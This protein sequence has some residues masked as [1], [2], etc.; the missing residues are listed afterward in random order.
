[1][2]EYVFTGT[3][4]QTKSQGIYGFLQKDGKV[5]QPELLA[6]RVSPTYLAVNKA[7]TRLYAVDEP[8]EGPGTLGS[9]IIERNET[10]CVTG[11][12]LQ[13][14]VTAP[15]LGL[16][17]V[18]LSP[19]EKYLLCVSY[20]DAKLMVYALEEDGSIGT[21]TACLKRE[22][23]GPNPA[24]QEGAHAHSIT[25]VPNGSFF[26]LL[27]LGTDQLAAYRLEEGVTLHYLPH[28]VLKVH[29]P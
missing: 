6:E 9:Y 19:D 29:S 14:N 25:F 22:G 20:M 11:L 10:G 28:N 7:A 17:H 1:M 18:V 16:C 12:T 8:A 13:K 4:T 5:Y 26:Y 3:Y 24:R 2:Q 23:H 21:L 15:S 27:D